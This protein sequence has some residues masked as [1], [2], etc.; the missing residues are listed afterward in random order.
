M[1]P[2]KNFTRLLLP[3]IMA[4][5]ILGSCAT[6]PAPQPEPAP[7]EAPAAEPA[8]AQ[9]KAPAVSQADLDALLAQAKDLKKKAFDLKLFEVLPEDYKTADAALTTAAASYDAAS[10][11]A[12][13]APAAKESIE[14]SIAL[15]KDLIAKGVVELA[16]AKRDSADS[17]KSAALKAGA[18]TKAADRLA[19]ADEAYAAAAALIDQGKHEESIGVFE[20]ARLYYELAYKRSA[21]S[22]LRDRIASEDFAKWDSGNYQLAENKYSAEEGLWA[23]G[24]EA[25]RASGVDLLDE[26]ILRFNLVVQKGRQSVAIGAKEKSDDSKAKS[27]EVKAQVAVKDQYAA[28]LSTYD[29]AVAKL[30]SG[31]FEEATT[32]FESAQSA[33]DAAYEAAA[34][35]RA[36]AQAAMESAAAAAEDSARKA[37]E[38]DALVGPNPAP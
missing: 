24:A 16:K 23:S 37:E 9:P 7:A 1:I 10:K 17:M 35:K 4:V 19:A 12:K 27:E 14:K 21:A 31:D 26:S 3:A 33:F 32:G 8:P 28:A 11:D 2:V 20:R 6:K 13:E 25:D 15:F 5:A 38:A 30:A 34:D 22:D 29:E 18:D 36:K